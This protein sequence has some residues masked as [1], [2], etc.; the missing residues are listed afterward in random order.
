[1]QQVRWQRG[2]LWSHNCLGDAYA[3]EEEWER[4]LEEFNAAAVFSEPMYAHEPHDGL[5][6]QNITRTY[7][8]QAGVYKARA[9]Y[10][11]AEAKLR[12]CIE[13]R[14]A[15]PP[16]PEIATRAPLAQLY[17]ELGALH[18]ARGDAR[19]ALEPLEKALP[20][21]EALH[22]AVPS[23]FHYIAQLA[24]THESVARSQQKLRKFAAAH[25]S[26]ERAL[27]LREQ[28]ATDLAQTGARK[29]LA[30]CCEAL[31]TLHAE[32]AAAENISQNERIQR[33]NTARAYFE[34]SRGLLQT[35]HEKNP[36]H[37]AWKTTLDKITEH[38]T[39]CDQVLAAR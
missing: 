5:A 33:W 11:A 31:G 14:E 38:L 6:L 19:A 20:V 34:R 32:S 1:R 15:A 22:A 13:M 24:S 9:D 28:G 26:Y 39:H 3:L 30:L 10:A 21:Q 8:G 2:I 35:L 18:L 27:A 12:R 25:Q 4:A 17:S 23:N 37:T 7:A 16:E 36:Q 29:H